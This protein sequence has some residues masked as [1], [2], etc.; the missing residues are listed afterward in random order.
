M[1]HREVYRNEIG[2]IPEG[3]KWHIHHINGDKDDNSPQ[4][5][6]L[7]SAKEHAAEHM[8]DARRAQMRAWA[9]EI[10]PL[11]AAWHKSEEGR[12]WHRAHAIAVA[13]ARP[14]VATTCTECGAEFLVKQSKRQAAVC[15]NACRMRRYRATEA[16][17]EACRRATLRSKSRSTT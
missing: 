4:N 5:L 15:G 17:A 6:A 8:D 12:E 11:S 2:P 10:R 7:V 13:A 16:G 14:T 9:A 1:L 3:K